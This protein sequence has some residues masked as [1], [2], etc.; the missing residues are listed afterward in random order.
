MFASPAVPVSGP[1]F[2]SSVA[3]VRRADVRYSWHRGCPVGPSKLRLLEL[4]YWGFDGL[5]HVGRIVV[6]VAVVDEVTKVFKLL[7]EER[8]PIRRMFPLDVFAGNA[9]RS[10]A[11]DNTTAFD[12][13]RRGRAAGTG[14][15]LNPVENPEIVRG[16][17]TPPQGRKYL[18]RSVVRLGMAVRGGP[19]VQAFAL[20]GWTW[21]GL[22]RPPEYEHFSAN[23]R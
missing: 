1:S 16:V 5:P 8:F 20:S 17:V 12:C 13:R 14:I 23:A 11:A 15:D 6:N 10:M 18:K 9:A 22:W 4:G 2:T 3:I 21:G 7:W 19:L